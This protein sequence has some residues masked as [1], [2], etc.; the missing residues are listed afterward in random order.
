M[1]KR[2]EEFL[3]LKNRLLRIR[4]RHLRNELELIKEEYESRTKNYFDIYHDIEKRV[5]ERT[6]EAK[7]LQERLSRA[8]KMEALGLLAGGVAHE[9]NN[10][11]SSIMGYPDLIMMRMEKGLPPEMKYISAIKQAGVRSKDIVEDLLTITRRKV[12]EFSPL[13]MNEVLQDYMESPEFEHLKQALPKIDYSFS[14]YPQELTVSGS[15]THI[16]KCLANL[17]SNAAESMEGRNGKVKVTLNQEKLESSQTNFCF[18]IL[19]EEYAVFSICDNGHGISKA[20]QRR[21]FEPFYTTKKMGRS[22]T[23]L[24]L[25]VVWGTVKDHNGNI[26]VESSVNTGTCFK[27]YF[28][29]CKEKPVIND[30]VEKPVS[31]SFKGYSA[32]IICENDTQTEFFTN[33]LKELEFTI[34]P[35]ISFTEIA[36]CPEKEKTDLLL[37][38]LNR[39]KTF[40]STL[41]KPFLEKKADQK[42]IVISTRRPETEEI[43]EILQN[44]NG[45]YLKQ[46]FI[47]SRIAG[48]IRLLFS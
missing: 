3:K 29:L 39:E 32:R 4:M 13:S 17:V 45:A 44:G 2:N 19:E 9:L 42:F 12:Q 35:N 7:D 31:S 6:Q 18:D 23:G 11:L 24:G 37:V 14:G 27:L 38:Y 21:L 15:K 25:S 41:L 43:S 46:P 26:K 8:E 48:K 28:P 33:V 22:G 34:K 47:L 1:G 36:D 5:V 30:E 20:D 40:S 16:F 10:L